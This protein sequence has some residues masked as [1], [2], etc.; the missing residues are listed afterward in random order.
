VTLENWKDLATIVGVGVAAFTFV[1]VLIE[2]R[3]QGTQKGVERFLE[4]RKRFKENEL[5][6][7][8]V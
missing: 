3:D 8:V 4:M 5:L 7:H 1:K 2:Y 6:A